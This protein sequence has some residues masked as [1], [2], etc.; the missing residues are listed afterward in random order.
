MFILK[1]F[2]RNDLRRF[3][4]EVENVNRQFESIQHNQQFRSSS[5]D[6]NGHNQHTRQRLEN[7]KLQVNVIRDESTN[8]HNK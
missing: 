5:F 3:E 2:E 6:P 1:E 8:Y 4:R 7:I